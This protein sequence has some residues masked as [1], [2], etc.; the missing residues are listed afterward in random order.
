MSQL[1][2]EEIN[3]ILS[4]AMEASRQGDR[5]KYLEIMKPIPTAPW[6]ALAIKEV[7]GAEYLEGRNLT[8]AEAEYG[9]DWLSK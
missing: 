7:F 8:E 6:L 1:T 5:E 4:Q 3:S 9:K 2:H